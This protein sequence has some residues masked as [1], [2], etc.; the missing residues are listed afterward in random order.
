[1]SN[2]DHQDFSTVNIGSKTFS[3][4]KVYKVTKTSPK[5][6]S[7]IVKKISDKKKKAKIIGTNIQKGRMAKGYK[8]KQLAQFLSIKHKHVQ[9][10][11]NG[12]SMPGQKMISKLEKLLNIH[13]QG[14]NV[15]M[16]I[17]E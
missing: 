10:Y 12:T 11:E 8:Q 14:K 7:D 17:T 9:D 2:Y 3:K 4:K 1:M 6:Q 5:T 16:E 15:G 13:L